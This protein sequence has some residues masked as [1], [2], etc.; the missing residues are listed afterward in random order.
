MSP[1]TRKS[2]CFASLLVAIALPSA[3]LAGGGPEN[4]FLLV[5]RRSWQSQTVANHYIQLRGIPASNVL[6][7]DWDG[8]P[9][10]TSIDLFR[11]KILQPAL[12]AMAQRGLAGQIDY[13]IYSSDFSYS[14]D[15][16]GEAPSDIPADNRRAFAPTGSING[17]TYLWQ[18]VM[19]RSPGYFAR[20]M[21]EYMRH[22]ESQPRDNQ[23]RGFRSWYGWGSNGSLRETGGRHYL[24]STMLAV[25]SGSG[26]SVPEVISYLERSAKAD[27]TK[28]RG[29]I[30]Y[31]N[32]P[33]DP[34]RSRPRH[35]LFSD[36]VKK[37]RT[38]GVE[39]EVLTGN[40]P[41][42][43]RDVQGVMLGTAKFNWEQTGST[44]LPGA[45][46]D[47]FTSF[48]GVMRKG[49]RS[50]TTLAEF[51]RHGAAG[52]S[53]TVV[54]PLAILDKFP[55]PLI[56]YHYAQG[57]TL[58][59]AFYQ[60]VFWPYQLLIV[61]DPLCRPWAKIPQV[62][63]SGVTAKAKVK[64]SIALRPTAKGGATIARFELFVDG[65]RHSKC[66]PGAALTLDTTTLPDGYHELRVVA[67]DATPIE[68][69][70]RAVIPVAIDNGGK[71]L[72][73]TASVTKTAR[74][75]QTL[76]FSA[77]SDG[78]DSIVVMHNH[79]PLG[80]IQG[81]KGRVSI[82]PKELGRGP[83]TV[84]AVAVGKRDG[85]QYPLAVAAPVQ[86]SVVE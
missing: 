69:Q 8:G 43:K 73:L 23:T 37:L 6:S 84:S 14:I 1:V 62:T 67:I 12:E 50:Q 33:E 20:N 85:Q 2:L 60:S 58:A 41:T 15:L 78:A 79:R 4:V 61:G 82:N 81:A 22:S 24:L 71:K 11:Q 74:W 65:V 35:D 19:A 52:A 77:A 64:G 59:E 46:A 75:G 10:S 7:L 32:N 63:V 31:A 49:G 42:N 29:T 17:V 16:S 53:G 68:T 34:R 54:E 47:H 86:L 36:A 57:C 56:H 70:G 27:G 44:L 48:G 5:N 76:V 18:F 72:T 30:Y 39:A 55:H 25:T 3:G 83:V 45:I 13:L 21:N 51:M 9:D 40:A 80:T 38:V 28:P 66:K 26:N